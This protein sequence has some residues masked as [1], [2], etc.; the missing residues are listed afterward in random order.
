ML[1]TA[2]GGT[3]DGA[4]TQWRF[5]KHGTYDTKFKVTHDTQSRV[6]HNTQLKVTNDSIIYSRWT[7]NLSLTLV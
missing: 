2:T 4:A 3:G 1:I 5:T 7:G 6:T